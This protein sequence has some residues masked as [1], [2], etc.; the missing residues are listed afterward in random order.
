MYLFDLGML[1]VVLLTHVDSMDLITKGDL[2]DIYRCI[3][4][5]QK[6]MMSFVDT[7]SRI[8]HYNHIILPCIK[9]KMGTY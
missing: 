7:L 1:H 2:T 5:K 6:V 8:R 9:I 4:V 3:P